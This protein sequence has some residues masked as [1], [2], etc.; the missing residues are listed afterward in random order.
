[1]TPR[2]FGRYFRNGEQSS[3]I[4]RV[5]LLNDENATKDSPAPRTIVLG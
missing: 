2:A 1:V 4:H 3:A 5:Y